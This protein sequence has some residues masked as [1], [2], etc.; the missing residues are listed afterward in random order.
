MLFNLASVGYEIIDTFKQV[1]IWQLL[2]SEPL[3]FFNMYI[4]LVSEFILRKFY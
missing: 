3:L 1:I 4:F 2:K